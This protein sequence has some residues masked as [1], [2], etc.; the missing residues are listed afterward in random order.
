M[1][2]QVRLIRILRPGPIQPPQNLLTLSSVEDDALGEELRVIWELEAG[3]A[4]IGKVALP[5]P[6][7]FDP[8]ARRYGPHPVSGQSW[9]R[10]RRLPARSRC[11][12]DTDAPGLAF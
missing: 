6:T 9:Y 8:P 4:I 7:G 11:P 12:G 2:C 10:Y 5:E 1:L 3:A